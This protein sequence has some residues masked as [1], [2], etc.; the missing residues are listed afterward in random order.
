MNYIENGYKTLVSND[1]DI[2]LKDIEDYMRGTRVR[3]GA[4]MRLFKTGQSLGR[5]M[6]WIHRLGGQL[7]EQQDAAR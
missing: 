1:Y 6:G 5:H 2:I 3:C 4:C 7:G